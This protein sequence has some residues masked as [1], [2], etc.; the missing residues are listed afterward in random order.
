MVIYPCL[1]TET[2][3]NTRSGLTWVTQ[4]RTSGSRTKISQP[5][6]PSAALASIW[7]PIPHFSAMGNAASGSCY[8]GPDTSQYLFS[9][10]ASLSA[11]RDTVESHS[12]QREKHNWELINPVRHASGKKHTLWSDSSEQFFPVSFNNQNFYAFH[13]LSKTLTTAIK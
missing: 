1:S 7:L 2:G 3:Y 10:T 11:N 13:D 12:A 8:L 5:P 9:S 4:T 6:Q